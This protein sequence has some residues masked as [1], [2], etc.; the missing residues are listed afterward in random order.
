M[1]K[2]SDEDYSYQYSGL[3]D[4]EIKERILEGKAN[5]LPKSPSRT[6]GEIIKANLFTAYNGI[7]MILAVFAIV[8]GSPK[9]ALF[10]GVIVTNTLIG[11]VQE[12]RAKK[13]IENLSV[14]N[15]I[16]VPVMRDGKEAI[17]GIEEIVLD[18]IVIL[19]PGM[20]I[21]ADSIVLEG[22]EVEMDESLLTGETD[23]CICKGY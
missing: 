16:K 10:A 9:N 13:V 6:V 18:D 14:V 21:A 22:S 23:I 2:T 15:A 4:Y 12:I 19:K 3:K 7:N 1:D 17:I 5:I 20:Q 8:A 11:I